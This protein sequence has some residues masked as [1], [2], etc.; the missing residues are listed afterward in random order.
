MHTEYNRRRAAEMRAQGKSLLEIAKALKRPSGYTER[1]V[2]KLLEKSV[3]ASDCAIPLFDDSQELI[4]T[5]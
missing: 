2:R 3:Q 4:P 1:G 5:K